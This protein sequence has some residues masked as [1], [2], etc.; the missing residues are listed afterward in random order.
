MIMYIVI[1]NKK[2]YVFFIILIYGKLTVNIKI[3]N[4]GYSI[5]EF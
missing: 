3:I 5:I 4:L 1:L 2:I